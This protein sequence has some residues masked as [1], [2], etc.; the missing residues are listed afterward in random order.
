MINVWKSPVSVQAISLLICGFGA[1]GDP[2][3]AQSENIRAAPIS[4]DRLDSPPPAAAPRIDH[5]KLLEG[6]YKRMQ[7]RRKSHEKEEAVATPTYGD[8]LSKAL[9]DETQKPHARNFFL[10]VAVVG[11]AVATLESRQGY[12]SEPTMHFGG[13]YRLTQKSDSPAQASARPEKTP[14]LWLGLRVAPFNGSGFY[15]G[16][17]G[18]YG[19]TYFGPMI[20]VGKIDPPASEGSSEAGTASAQATKRGRPILSGWLVSGGVAAVSKQGR[21]DVAGDAKSDFRVK[22]VAFDAPG[23]WVEFRQ[24]A[25]LFGALGCNLVAGLQ[26]GQDKVFFYGGVGFA[27]WE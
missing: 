25:V 27:G 12:T 15:R 5:D 18:S 14:D 24:M 4:I 26:T 20:A 2:L 6:D 21:S 8:K 17:P 19:L 13:A 7:R 23:V 3:R 1:A 16:H 10:E 11:S 22:G 9:D